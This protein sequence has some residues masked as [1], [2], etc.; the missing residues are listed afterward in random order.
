MVTH[1]VAKNTGA[2]SAALRKWRKD[3]L[4]HLHPGDVLKAAPDA[5]RSVKEINYGQDNKGIP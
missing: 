5:G 4:E 1:K 3:F 2:R